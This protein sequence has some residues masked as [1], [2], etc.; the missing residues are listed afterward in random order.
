MI[1][2]DC[3]EMVTMVNVVVMVGSCGKPEDN[4]EDDDKILSHCLELDKSG[5][6]CWAGS[7]PGPRTWL[8]KYFTSP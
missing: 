1:Y 3:D 4:G 8:K 2:D 6:L 5:G 7:D